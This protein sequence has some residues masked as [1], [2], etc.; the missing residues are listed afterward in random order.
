M[1]LTNSVADLPA[2]R[3][4]SAWLAT[5]STALGYRR[6]QIGVVITLIVL[7]IAFL[8][9]LFSP[10][11]PSA[12][13]SKPFAKPSADLLLGT[14]VRGRDVLSRVLNGGLAVVWMSVAAASVGMV[15]GAS[16]GMLAAYSRGWLGELLMRVMDVF[17]ALP[18]IILVLMVVSLLGPQQ[19]LIV[20]LVG[21]SHMPQVARVTQGVTADVV[22]RDFVLFA[23]ALNVPRWKILF[24]EILPNIMTPL[25]VEYGMR[26]VWAIAGIAALSVMGYG[27]QPPD[28]DWGLLINENRGRLATRPLPVLVPAVLIALFALGVNLMAEGLSATISGVARKTGAK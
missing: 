19:W 9:P 16:V 7:L 22:R 4:K 12:F 27:I 3:P 8:G 28:A 17:L 21:I 2:L 1:A 13:V 5:L 10:N 23:E 15:L 26:I 14:D 24:R 25:L 20:L 6:T 18:T 11:E